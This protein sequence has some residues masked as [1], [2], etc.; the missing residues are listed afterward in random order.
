MYWDI[1]RFFGV[2]GQR[3]NAPDTVARAV[4][5]FLRTPEDFSS[6]CSVASLG[7]AASLN[8]MAVGGLV[9]AYGGVSRIPKDLVDGVR[10]GAK[11]EVVGRKLVQ[12]TKD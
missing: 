12:T 3:E 2:I 9:G 6:V 4:Y 5:A 8:A 1:P 10:N 7:G 11:I